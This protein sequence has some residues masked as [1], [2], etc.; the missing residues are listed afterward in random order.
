MIHP[1]AIVEDFVYIGKDTRIWHFAHIRSHAIIGE[2]CNIGKDVFVDA[3]VR[4]GN[5]CKIQNGVSVYHGVTLDDAVFVGPNVTFTNDKYPRAVGDW[6]VSPTYIERGASIGAGAVI[7]A[8]ITIGAFAMIGAG[9]VVTHDV[10]PHALVYGN[11]AQIAGYVCERGHKLTAMPGS[12]SYE[13][14]QCQYIHP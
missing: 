10:P 8:G 2:G 12:T 6:C 4:I 3:G 14:I 1:T 9:A 5:H 13:C 7:V 11:P